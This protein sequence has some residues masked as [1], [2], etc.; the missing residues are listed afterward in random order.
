M[1]STSRTVLGGRATPGSAGRSVAWS[2]A[3]YVFQ[4]A[5]NL[6]TTAYVVRR[7]SVAE[8]GLLLF[9][10]SLSASL[11]LLDMGISGVLVQSYVTVLAGQEEG[12][13]SELI[14]TAFWGLAMLGFVG[15]LI[16]SAIAA[17]LPGPFNIPPQ[18]VHEAAIIFVIAA[19]VIQVSLPRGALEQAYQASNRYD[20]INQIQLLTTAVQFALS[21]AVLAA[22]YRIVAL[23]IVQLVTALL[24]L[25]LLILALPA[26]VP[27]ASLGLTGF[28]WALLK[29]VM[30]QG[31]WAFIDNLGFCLFNV[32]VWSILGSLSSLKEVAMFG[33]AARL[34]TQLR[35]AV[36]KGAHVALPLMSERAANNA[37]NELREIFFRTQK[38]VFGAILPFIVLGWVFAR[39]LIAVWAGNEYVKAANVMQLLLLAALGDSILYSSGT[40][41][42]ASG[43]VKRAAWMSVVLNAVSVCGVL[44]TASRYGSVGVACVIAITQLFLGGGWFTFA[45]CR[46]CRG[47]PIVLA[48]DALG[49]VAVPGVLMIVATAIVA[50][51][52]KALPPLWSVGAATVIGCTYL[53]VWSSRAAIPLFRRR[54]ETA[55]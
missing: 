42:Y 25:V 29:P 2:Y 15:V 20:R 41:L 1:Q 21:V 22:G 5:V 19:L 55:L 13:L 10:L 49:E 9:V 32:L 54:T 34:P 11:Y 35:N 33:L 47:S 26:S 38:L 4:I 8:Y 17:I 28:K 24:S 48:R 40:L 30:N 16:F 37:M 53:L 23:A 6:G 44:L 43:Q 14:S 45:A 36:E 39:P 7:V 50:I 46:V 51:L 12:R 27:Q 52:G 31:K 3:G 18:Y